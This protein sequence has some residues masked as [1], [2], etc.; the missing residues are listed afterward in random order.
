M[1]G[2]IRT[3]KSIFS[4]YRDQ[5]NDQYGDS[6]NSVQSLC[7][8]EGYVTDGTDCNDND[9][10]IHP[11]APETINGIDDNC[12]GQ[13]D[14]DLEACNN[15]PPI[16]DTI[17]E[18]L[19]QVIGDM[20][21]G[22]T[23]A[24]PFNVVFKA[25]NT[26][27]LEVNFQ[28]DIGATLDAL[29]EDCP[30]LAAGVTISQKKIKSKNINPS[31][32]NNQSYANQLD[33]Y[34]DQWNRVIISFDLE[35]SSKVILTL[36]NINGAEPVPLIDEEMMSFGAHEMIFENHLHQKG[37]YFVLLKTNYEVHSRRLVINN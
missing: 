4:L 24:S 21:S 32:D 25:T 7:P 9:A 27:V 5:D 26:I 8:I 13:I 10:N 16:V 12:N 23:V 19:Y 1:F 15:P 3:L 20:N 30:S 34:S 17:V 11:D 2:N 31:F 36:E 28:V 18:G 37:I 22:G 35:K 29:I 6:N 14:E 33:V